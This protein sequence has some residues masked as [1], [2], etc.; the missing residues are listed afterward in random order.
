MD[1]KRRRSAFTL[2]ELLVV[3]SIVALLISLL[4]PALSKARA[5]AQQAKCQIHV[6]QIVTA[7]YLYAQDHKE[8]FWPVSDRLTW[9]NGRRNWPTPPNQRPGDPPPTDV[10]YWAQLVDRATR[11][12]K[13]GFLFTYVQNAHKIVEC[14]TNKRAV[15]TTTEYNNLWGGTTGVEFDFTMLDEVEG[16][17]LGSSIQVGFL[18]PASN[19]AARIL[20]TA[21]AQTLTLLPSVPLFFEES[22]FRYNQ[23]FRDGMFGNEDQVAS[24]HNRSGHVGYVD[25]SASLFPGWNDGKEQIVDRTT[26]FECL[27][28]YATAGS[29]WVSISDNDWRF[30]VIQGFGW[31]NNPK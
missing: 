17:R 3:I 4:L 6:K 22:S 7:A 8:Q 28:L 16:F 11:D 13:P 10:A 31:I 30:N 27:D 14:P 12:R 29:R 25:G 18:P 2:I 24:R 21:Q 20:S 26:E 9:P 19:N 23:Q 5:V 15:P 1:R